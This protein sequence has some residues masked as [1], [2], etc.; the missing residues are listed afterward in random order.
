MIDNPSDVL[1]ELGEIR[2]LAEKGI[3]Y[4]AEAEQKFV[5]LESEADRV[6]SLA[7]LESQGSVADR[8]HI[9]RL[10]ALEAREAAELAKVEVNR[11]KLKLKHLSES[12][13]NIQTQAK[14]IE[15]EWRNAGL[16]RS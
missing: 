2:D 5:R 13:M 12:Q 6:E 7:F 3:S 8:N 1:R 16:G 10:K 15:L 14:M 11:V 9:A 4:L